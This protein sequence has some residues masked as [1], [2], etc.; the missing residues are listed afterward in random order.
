MAVLDNPKH[1]RFA[2]ALAAGETTDGA[3]KLAGYKANRGNAVRLKANESIA[4]RVRELL[5]QAAEKVGITQERVLSELGKIGFS[6]IRKAFTPGGA[7]LPPEEWDDDFAASVAGIEVV[8]RSTNEK[9]ADGHTVVEHVHKFKTWDKRA[10]L[11]DLGKHLGMF[12]D[13]AKAGDIHIHFDAE[14]KGVL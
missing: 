9:D 3:Y 8:S 6:D 7:I 4:A 5:G 1:E 12:K 10:A 11:V 14:L 13:D 2:Q